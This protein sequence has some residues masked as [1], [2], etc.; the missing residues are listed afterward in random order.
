MVASLVSA[1]M[2]L[3]R[4]EGSPTVEIPRPFQTVRPDCE[5]NSTEPVGRPYEDARYY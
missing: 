3:G 5:P 1:T 2:R 4:R